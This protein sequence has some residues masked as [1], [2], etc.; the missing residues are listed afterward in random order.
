MLLYGCSS[1]FVPFE[2]TPHPAE[3]KAATE[4]RIGVCYNGWFSEPEKVRAVAA[5][6]C[7]P[8]QKPVLV[9]QDMY[10]TCP[11]LDPVRATFSCVAE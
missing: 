1:I 7:G 3:T 9:T 5:A 11:L 8:G 6:A 4:N 2:G 10:L